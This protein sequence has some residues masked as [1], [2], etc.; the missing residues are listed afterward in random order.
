MP[1]FFRRA[2]DL[3]QLGTSAWKL[4]QASDPA[5]AANARLA[6]IQTMGRLRGLPQKVGQILSMGDDESADDFRPLTD[7]AQPL[8]FPVIQKTLEA[9]WKKPLASV[10]HDVNPS[11]LAASLGQV[12]HARLITNDTEVAI[13]VRYPGIENSVASDLNLLGWLSSPFGGLRKQ[14]FDMDAYRAEVLRDLEE[15]LDYRVEAQNI[16]RF[17]EAVSLPYVVIPQ[18]VEPLCRDNVLVMSWEEGEGIEEVARTWSPKDRKE[19][20]RRL[21]V[22]F[23]ESL[24]GEGIVHADP[25]PGNYRFRLERGEPRIVLYDFGSLFQLTET[26]Q[27]A[28]ARLMLATLQDRAEDPFPLFVLL[29]FDPATLAPLRHKL[30]PLCRVLFEPFC[31]EV[32]YP[33]GQWNRSERVS[34]ILGDDRW[35]FRISGP[36]RMIFLM[37]AFHG[38]VYYLEQLQEPVNWTW[39]CRPIVKRLERAAA[40]LS[41]P[42][43]PN[44]EATFARLA[45]YLNIQ[46]RENGST[47]VKITLP[48]IAVDSLHEYIDEDVE[49]K[50]R[51]RGIHLDKLIHQVRRDG[52][53]PCELFELDDPPKQF[54]VWME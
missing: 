11:G 53:R 48:A 7:K 32:P 26:E 52:Y 34:D 24:F 4:R 50:I 2:F 22:L 5:V 15:E 29:G 37:R 19:L 30:A 31:A 54:R 17:H 46:V 8:P 49:N 21:L 16:V 44:P 13:K 39:F 40:E 6:L 9:A 51:E 33:L 3:V 20:G 47:K 12:H 35:N 36:A 38:L 28:L 14:H 45:R 1:G 43:E 27:L 23:F 10:V 41:L 18:L 42:A 25:H